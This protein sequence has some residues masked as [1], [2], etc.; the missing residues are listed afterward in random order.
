MTT[1][2]RKPGAGRLPE[3]TFAPADYRRWADR[4]KQI[5]DPIRL[6]VVWGL[7]D[8]DRHVGALRSEIACSMSTLSR[9]LALL[10]LN[11]L[12]QRRRDGQRNVYALTDNGRALWRL[13]G[14]LVNV[15]TDGDGTR[16]SG[17]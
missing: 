17:E 8:G 5:S 10:R 11:G 12:V 15:A 6:G 1:I 7:G 2:R 14:G 3:R 16:S 13:I 4:L 9:H